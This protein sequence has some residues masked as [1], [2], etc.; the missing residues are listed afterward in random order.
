MAE[1]RTWSTPVARWFLFWVLL[2]LALTIVWYVLPY[3]V[4]PNYRNEF[5]TFKLGLLGVL[6]AISTFQWEWWQGFA[7]RELRQVDDP[8]WT[9]WV[10]RF[11][12]I[13]DRE[14]QAARRR[15]VAEWLR[16]RRTAARQVLRSSLVPIRFALTTLASAMYL[17]IVSLLA[18]LVAILDGS[19]RLSDVISLGA[20]S[21][22]L[23]ASIALWCVHLYTLSENF[24]S[25]ERAFRSAVRGH[26]DEG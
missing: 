20:F 10:R 7:Y 12:S 24:N 6:A 14:S 17:L 3:A 9:V 23:I 21:A 13:P 8:A 15:D 25:W 26:R 19:S 1:R 18:D 22:A 2:G 5:L 4:P 11:R 16:W